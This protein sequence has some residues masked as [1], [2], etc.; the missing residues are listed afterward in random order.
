MPDVKHYV[1]KAQETKTLVKLMQ[2][3]THDVV[4]LQYPEK[5]TFTCIEWGNITVDIKDG[6]V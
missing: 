3:L 2:G 4:I 5:I 1:M 6:N